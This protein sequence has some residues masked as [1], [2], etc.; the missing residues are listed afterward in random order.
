[1]EKDA[2]RERILFHVYE[3]IKICCSIRYARDGLAIFWIYIRERERRTRKISL[4]SEKKWG[5][6]RRNDFLTMDR[7][8]DCVLE[9][10][11]PFIV[12]VC[13]SRDPNCKV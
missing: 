6:S 10:L 8:I 13:S 2:Q 9:A 1:M 7:V 4:T 3:F 11:C 12:L 5:N